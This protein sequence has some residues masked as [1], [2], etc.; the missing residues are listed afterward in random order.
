MSVS[1]THRPLYPTPTT[2][3]QSISLSLLGLADRS[4]CSNAVGGENARMRVGGIP[5]ALYCHIWFAMVIWV[6]YLTLLTPEA[7]YS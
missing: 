5:I 4:E 1:G 7:M 2:V 6:Q 3:I